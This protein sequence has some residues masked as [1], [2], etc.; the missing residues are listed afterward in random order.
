M[1]TTP[2]DRKVDVLKEAR[3]L[4]DAWCDRH[5]YDAIC[6][7]W[8]GLR[9]INGLTDGWEEFLKTLKHL[10]ILAKN[11]NSGMTQAEVDKVQLLIGV[12]SRALNS[13]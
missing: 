4:L 1:T 2:E 9:S 5:S 10:R 12:V 8:V 13:R 6:A 3:Q 7:I 11:E